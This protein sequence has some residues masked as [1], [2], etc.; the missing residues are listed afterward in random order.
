MNRDEQIAAWNSMDLTVEEVEPVSAEE[1]KMRR[2]C[3]ANSHNPK[4]LAWIEKNPPPKDW[5][6]SKLQWAYTEMPWG[7]FFGW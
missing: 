5:K 1:R 7:G 4:V 2:W 3:R 6:G